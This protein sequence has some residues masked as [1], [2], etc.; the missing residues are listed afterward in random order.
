MMQK[1]KKKC[2]MK[3]NKNVHIYRKL[4]F[5]KLNHIKKLSL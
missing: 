4:A 2:P 3:E 1:L 5:R